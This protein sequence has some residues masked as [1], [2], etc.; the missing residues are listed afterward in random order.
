MKD[1]N[2][3]KFVNESNEKYN[4][5]YCDN[6]RLKEELEEVKKSTEKLQENKLNSDEQFKV[7][8]LRLSQEKQQL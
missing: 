3:N 7:E 6:L 5:L 1:D 2:M 4:L 8:I